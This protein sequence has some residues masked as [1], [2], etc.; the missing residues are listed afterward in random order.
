[1]QDWDIQRCLA[2]DGG[3][4]WHVGPE[5]PSEE[6]LNVMSQRNCENNVVKTTFDNFF[7]DLHQRL[8]RRNVT[9]LLEWQDDL[10]QNSL[11]DLRS[12]GGYYSLSQ[13]D[14][15]LGQPEANACIQIIPPFPENLT[16]KATLQIAESHSPSDWVG[17]WARGRTP[18]YLDGNLVFLRQN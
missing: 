11:K 13:G 16:L 2:N 17:L 14:L 9:P 1:M 10:Q 15:V 18:S 6:I 5:G 8:L 12:C 4:I 7:R 3:S